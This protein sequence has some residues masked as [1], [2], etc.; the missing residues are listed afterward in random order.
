MLTTDGS[1]PAFVA[2]HGFVDYLVRVA[3][4][5]GVAHVDAYRMATLNPATHYGLDQEIGGIAPGRF[6]DILLL[7]DLG[8]PTP[9]SVIARGRLVARDGR[10]LAD[11]EEPSWGRIL[12][13]PAARFAPRLAVRAETF[14]RPAAGPVPVIRLVSA[15]ITR[16]ESRSREEGD[17]LAAL[18]DR[19]GGW[20][21]QGLLAGFARDLDGLA[22]TMSTDFQILALGRDP[23]AMALAV[24]RLLE[25]E[26]GIVVVEGGRAIWELALPLGG[27]MG[28]APLPELAARERELRDLLKARG[29]VFH[30]PL[31]TLLFLTA[32]FLPEVRLTARG[33]WDVR[34]RR[35]L[36]PSRPLPGGARRRSGGRGTSNAAPGV[37]P[38]GRFV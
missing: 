37:V 15:V 12:R 23:S 5:E 8:E 24:R 34:G 20:I 17:L 7:R 1:G 16:L 10:L 4:E 3:L 38:G 25:L 33:V 30:D 9:E 11:F 31:F 28:P 32:D 27:I 35:V 22:T 26:G 19:H 14:G 6:A 36:V 18:L 29:H 2:E 21:S 13:V